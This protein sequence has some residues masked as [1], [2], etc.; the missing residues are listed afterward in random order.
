MPENDLVG[1]HKTEIPTPALLVDMAAVE[2]NIAM[3]ADFFSDKACNLRPHC[4]T[5]KLPEI[6][7][8]EI[9]AGAVGITCATLR[10]AEVMLHSGIGSVLI[11]NEIVSKA[12]IDKMVTLASE[13]ELIVCV[14]HIE[15][16]RQIAET[17]KVAGQRMNV[18]IDLNI[19][20][21]RCGVMPG[22]PALDLARQVAELDHLALCGVMGYE[23]SLPLTDLNEKREKCSA[24]NK[25]LVDTADLIAHEGIPVD[26][27]S[28]GGSNTHTLTG[29]YPGITELQAGSYSTMDVHNKECGLPFEETL[30]VLATVVSRPEK[31]RA[32]IDAGHKAISSEFGIPG[33]TT[34]GLSVF[35]LNEEHGHLQIAEE[36]SDLKIGDLL[37][38]RPTHGCTTLPLY[39]THYLM[40]DD[41]VEKVVEVRARR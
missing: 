38:L 20:F 37:E 27:V 5:H 40:R 18:L 22:A 33:F 32:V 7:L 11:A 39:T 34:N 35:L 36:A 4:K 16:A 23:G 31:R 25:L 17:A 28:G 12:A 14:D 6:A 13:G 1:R 10:E 15:N 21:N 29:T 30:T 3:M 24:A 41:Q 2:R 19:G 9:E 26:I 8:K